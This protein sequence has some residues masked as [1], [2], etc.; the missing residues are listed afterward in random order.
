MLTTH[1]SIM[2]GSYRWDEERLPRDEFDIR[3]AHI[4]AAMRRNHWSAILLYGDAREHSGLAF[5]SNFIPR[6]RWALAIIP[7]EGEPRLLSSMSW[8]DMPAMRTMTW[9]ADVRSG[10]EWRW[11]EEAVGAL[12]AQGTIGAIGFEGMTPGLFAQVEKALAGG[13]ALQNADDVLAEARRTHRPREIALLAEAAKI[14][15]AAA[16]EIEAAWIGGQDLGLA[17]LAGE[18]MARRMAAQ[19]VRTLI[20]RDGGRTLEPYAA[21]ACGRPDRFVACVAVKYMGYWAEEFVGDERDPLFVE[22]QSNL[23]RLLAD[24]RAGALMEG[25][26][27]KLE[28]KVLPA[29]RF[30]GESLGNRIGLSANEGEELRAG[31]PVRADIVYALR[32]YAA[33]AAGEAAVASAMAV[34]RR[35]GRRQILTRSRGAGAPEVA[36]DA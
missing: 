11:F 18:R 5:F 29:P 20:S 31:A 17:V 24:L 9:I 16:A 19:D 27:E 13:R 21:G 28:R 10:W 1:P 36:A 32:A 34:V 8:R 23:R 7:S 2:L 15:R 22:A 30:L 14:V 35:D 3:L 33:N 12:P 25:I 4:Y 6:M 26:G